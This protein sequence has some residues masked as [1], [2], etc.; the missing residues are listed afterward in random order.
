MKPDK[1]IEEK[2]GL[3]GN[4]FLDDIAR[5]IWLNTWVNREEQ[6]KEW[7]KIISYAVSP[8]KNYI[9]FVIG[10]YGRGKTLSL[11][12]I[13]DE[14]KKYDAMLPKYLT[15]KGEQ[16]PKNPGLDFIFRIFKS[17]SFEELK[18]NRSE[19]ALEKAIEDLSADLEEVKTILRKIYLGESDEQKLA[20]YFLKG[21][22]RPTQSQ[23]KTLEVI[24][25]IQDID[26]AKEYL[27][28]VLGFIK[29]LGFST[30]L[31]AI[32]E[33]EYL[34]SLVPKTQQGI[35]LA[36]LR[37]LYDFP[38]G[39]VGKDVGDIANMALFIAISEDGWR[40]LKETEKKEISSGGPIQPLLDRVD[41]ETVL[42]AFDKRQ[43]R[44]LIEKR[45]TFNRIKGKY[46]DKPLI[47]FTEDFVKFLYDKANGEPR[48]IIIRC[49]QV[50][51]AG[52]EKG[53]AL[54]DRNFAQKALEERGWI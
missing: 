41:A 26:I 22:I 50:L 11:L 21:E 4:P 45:L 6:L 48:A 49:G 34:F 16:K 14:A 27:A 51:D 5:E 46:E 10:S 38:L 53:V 3:K 33:F 31:L 30:L 52:L 43:T 40:N 42:T 12:K 17:I 29:G 39:I 23:L 37:G 9:V 44:E 18:G 24:R 13:I 20:L 19:T 32:D 28:G 1:F 47:P 8:T 35:Y 25:K 54:L 15:F 2:Y 36:L 7:G